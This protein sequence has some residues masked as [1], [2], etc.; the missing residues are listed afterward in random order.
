MATSDTL[1]F[2]PVSDSQFGGA[3]T[4]AMRLRQGE[5]RRNSR[6]DTF[7][8]SMYKKRPRQKKTHDAE[9]PIH[10]RSVLFMRITMSELD[11]ARARQQ[12]LQH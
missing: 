8:Q 10:R 9:K 7:S 4:Q 6:H 1:S 3:N 5:S 11:G 12:L 2:T